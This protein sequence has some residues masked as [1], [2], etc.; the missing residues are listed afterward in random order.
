M[1]FGRYKTENDYIYVV[2]LFRSITITVVVFIYAIDTGSDLT[3]LSPDYVHG[4]IYIN[5]G[6]L[7]IYL[8]TFGHF[9][10]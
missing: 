10:L 5:I 8:Y 6:M 4:Y 7:Y 2:I 9:V 3:L 1:R